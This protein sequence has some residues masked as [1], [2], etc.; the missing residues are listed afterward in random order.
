MKHSAG[1]FRGAAESELYYQCW[2]PG[3]HTRAAIAVVP[4]LGDHSG[5]YTNVCSYFVPRSYAIYAFDTRGNGRSPG[6]RGYVSEWSEFREDLGFFLAFIREREHRAPLFL[7]G[8]SL[9]AVIALEYCLRRPEG[10]SG[11]I[12]AAPPL[13]EVGI[14]PFLWM[15]AH[16]LNRVW[17]RFSLN[18]GLDNS[19]LSR[20]PERGKDFKRDPL[21]H[22]RGT[23]RLAIEL[24]R[25]VEWIHAHAADLKLPLLILHGTADRIASSQGSRA[26]IRKVS[27][28]DSE[29][30]EYEGG[31]HE[32][33]ADINKDEV[34]AY[35]EQWLERHLKHARRSAASAPNVPSPQGER[36][37]RQ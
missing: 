26:F 37:S 9:G 17:P 21:T 12:C 13:G 18:T 33:Y 3:E 11:V 36:E 23:A 14:S 15:L 27:F 34:L 16:L 25:A 7:L 35:T 5:R 19:N 1:S 30:R 10:L 24:R 6:Q 29:L 8:E 4:G 31:Y 28:P 2:R 32:P 20:D 22:N